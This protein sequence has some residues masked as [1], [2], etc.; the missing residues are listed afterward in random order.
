MNIQEVKFQFT[1]NL[2]S[3]SSTRY[4]VV[5]HTAS[6]SDLTV[7]DIHRIHLNELYS[8]IGYH[9][10]I[11][12]AGNI[13]TGR[14]AWAIGSHALPINSVSV[15][16][17][18]SGNF[19]VEMPNKEQ[20]KSLSEILSYL[21]KTYPLA[22]VI[23][24]SQVKDT[25]ECQNEAKRTGYPLSYWATACC[26]QNLIKELPSLIKHEKEKIKLWIQ[27]NKARAVL[28][29]KWYSCELNKNI[30][31]GELHLLEE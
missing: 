5:H 13:F 19:E 4:I 6:K 18:V 2:T 16:V 10:Y 1:D 8:G 3:R 22:K 25:V 11:D 28:N 30:N 23:S 15:A 29:G 26:G 21:Q 9:Y 12:K 24:H 20:L 27:N 31:I 7:H 17:C 14:P